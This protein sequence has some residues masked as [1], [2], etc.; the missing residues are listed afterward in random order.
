MPSNGPSGS[1]IRRCRSA[2]LTLSRSPPTTDWYPVGSVR[3][4]QRARILA[5]HQ[6]L[7]LELFRKDFD[8]RYAGSVLGVLWTQLYPLL[9]LAVYS[10]VFTTIF[11]SNIPRF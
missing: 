10:F 6:E 7:L 4:I 1:Q 11:H 8:V 3:L 2:S 9:L 5:G